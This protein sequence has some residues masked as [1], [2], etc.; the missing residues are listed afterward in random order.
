[1][2]CYQWRG[3]ELRFNNKEEEHQKITQL[4]TKHTNQVNK[5][6]KGNI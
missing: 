6:L 5:Y 2:S 4:F 1:M 3:Y